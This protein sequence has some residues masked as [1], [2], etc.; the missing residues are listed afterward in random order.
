VETRPAVNWM[1]LSAVAAVVLLASPEQVQA[2][3]FKRKVTDSLKRVMGDQFY[4]KHAKTFSIGEN[5]ASLGMRVH[6][7]PIRPEKL[8]AECKAY[9]SQMRAQGKQVTWL[10]TGVGLIPKGEVNTNIGPINV[11]VAAGRTVALSMR[12]PV[13]G[14]DWKQQLRDTPNAL[15]PPISEKD[16]KATPRGFKGT[17]L[18]S[19]DYLLRAG[20]GR[21]WTLISG[22]GGNVG[23]HAGAS[24]NISRN[25]VYEVV[26]ERRGSADAYL[27]VMQLTKKALNTRVGLSASASP[28]LGS[29]LPTISNGLA[30]RAMDKV[31]GK[32]EKTIRSYARAGA[33]LTWSVGEQRMK[34]AVFQMNL[35]TNQVGGQ[36]NQRED[37]RFNNLGLDVYLSKLTVAQRISNSNQRHGSIKVVD[38]DGNAKTWSYDRARLDRR[39]AGIISD[40]ME[41]AR[42][43]QRELVTVTKDNGSE[44]SYYHT[45]YT[46][47]DRYTTKS[48][49]RRFM[50]FTS[51]IGGGGSVGDVVRGSDTKR[52]I[53]I[54]VSDAGLKTVAQISTHQPGRL[55]QAFASAYQAI[56][57]Y[58][59]GR[60]A[61]AEVPWLQRDPRKRAEAIRILKAYQSPHAQID[62]ESTLDQD[63]RRVAR[64]WNLQKDSAAFKQYEQ[65]SG[66]VGKLSRA[67]TPKARAQIFAKAKWLSIDNF[68]VG[69]ATIAKVA[70]LNNVKADISIRGEND[71]PVYLYQ[72]MAAE[73]IVDPQGRINHVMLYPTESL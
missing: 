52:T 71:R 13:V 20:V 39:Q 66:L 57:P 46:T 1:V 33:D 36:A 62:P 9:N 24:L 14:R 43:L 6:V 41:G 2:R 19:G 37:T 17:Y 12:M 69:A 35:H 4:R 48:N 18:V 5:G 26:V 22:R 29:L 27:S 32:A 63:Y 47:S 73:R 7:E 11:G 58:S 67:G 28:D 25:K 40:R 56:K 49:Q 55:A 10:E 30:D 44:V 45:R 8:G 23:A 50:R 42:H 16:L 70:G 31:V 3:D 65:L 60:R 61:L 15:R 68:W 53:D 51:F 34:K 72:S 54:S 59:R 21:N 38:A 64:G